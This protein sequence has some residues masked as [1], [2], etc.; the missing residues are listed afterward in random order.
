MP[1]TRRHIG[2]GIALL[3]LLALALVVR[4]AAAMRHIRGVLFSP[5]FPVVLLGLYAARPFLG[6]P[7]TF[8]STLVGF[9][10]GIAV[11]LPI[12]LAGVV[13]TSLIPYGAGRRFDLEGP[14]VGRFVGGSRQYFRTAGD[15]RGI[16]A[17][18]LAPTPAEP[19][20]A[21]AGFGG[22]SLWAFV[23]G[24]L[25]GELPWTIAAVTLGHSLS[26]YSLAKIEIDWWLG[27]AGL[28]AA[29]LLLA[30]PLYRAY[31]RRTA[32]A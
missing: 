20:S 12:A 21:A 23:L 9:R 1:V 11:G 4:P 6:W 29:L 30:G 5:W 32:S 7:I 19:V 17:A 31:R 8:L 22:V 27:A 18:R 25:I 28:L 14:L 10:Y 2:A 13:G 16:V 3:G 26:A 15:L 24:T